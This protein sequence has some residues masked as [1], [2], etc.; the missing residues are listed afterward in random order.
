[1][2][3]LKVIKKIC[4]TLYA[5]SKQRGLYYFLIM[6][7]SNFFAII[8]GITYRILFLKNIKGS[9]INSNDVRWDIPSEDIVIDSIEYEYTDEGKLILQNQFSGDRL[10]N[11]SVFGYDWRTKDLMEIQYFIQ[12]NIY[13]YKTENFKKE[14]D[15]HGNLTMN[16]TIEIENSKI[17]LESIK[18]YYYEDDQSSKQSYIPDL[19]FI[20]RHT[21]FCKGYQHVKP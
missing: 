8:R 2:R 9:I 10:I 13:P 1:M 5:E 17:K 19:S 21:V 7:V 18:H 12:D 14:Y 4:K 6:Y 16:R 3:V 15:L 11:H 20:S